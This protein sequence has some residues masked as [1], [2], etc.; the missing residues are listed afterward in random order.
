[1][2]KQKKINNKQYNFVNETII[3]GDTYTAY[4]CDADP[5]DTLVVKNFN[6]KDFKKSKDIKTDWQGGPHKLWQP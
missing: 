3:N 5:T 6:L 2:I 1:M 4:R